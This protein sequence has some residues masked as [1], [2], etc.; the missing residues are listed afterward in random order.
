MAAV[1]PTGG[2]VSDSAT[3]GDERL[4]P[5]DRRPPERITLRRADLELVAFFATA[6]LSDP[7]A[8]HERVERL[9]E[10]HAT[11]RLLVRR[12]SRLVAHSVTESKG[13]HTA[14]HLPTDAAEFFDALAMYADLIRGSAKRIR[15]Q[16]PASPIDG[17]APRQPRG[18]QLRIVD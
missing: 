10:V 17:A 3:S 4:H 15:T 5:S 7:A 14:W 16:L 1:R 6:R 11:G 2:A 9:D 12:L 13:S 18:P 8:E